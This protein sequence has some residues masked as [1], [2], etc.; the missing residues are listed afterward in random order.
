MPIVRTNTFLHSHTGMMFH[1]YSSGTAEL[2]VS[3]TS[4]AIYPTYMMTYVYSWYRVN[5]TPYVVVMRQTK[6]KDSNKEISS[7]NGRFCFN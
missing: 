5:T 7:V 6:G 3:N 4:Y 2:M 1:L